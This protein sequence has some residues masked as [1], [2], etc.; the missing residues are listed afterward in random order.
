MASARF[1]SAKQEVEFPPP[2]PS[3]LF[4]P[5]ISSLIYRMPPPKPERIAALSRELFN[6]PK[7]TTVNLSN[8]GVL[9]DSRDPRRAPKEALERDSL[10]LYINTPKYPQ[11]ELVVD[12]EKYSTDYLYYFLLHTKD[13]LK[14]ADF[15]HIRVPWIS[16]AR[17]EAFIKKMEDILDEPEP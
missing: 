13:M 15:Q 6:L 17:Q 10:I 5:G 8:V 16:R 3:P 4:F 7:C 14:Y 2:A 12:T 9:K 1:F 11:K